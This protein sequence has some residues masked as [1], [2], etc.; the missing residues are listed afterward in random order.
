MSDT[1]PY[2]GQVAALDQAIASFPYLARMWRALFVAFVA[3][4][5][6]EDQALAMTTETM[7]M[8]PIPCQDDA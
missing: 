6:T 7:A 1:D 8:Q 5:F 2:A 4:G 3:E